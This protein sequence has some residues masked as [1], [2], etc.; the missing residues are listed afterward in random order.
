M[1][2]NPF[3]CDAN[4]LATL[5]NCNSDTGTPKSIRSDGDIVKSVTLAGAFVPA[6]WATGGKELTMDEVKGMYRT[7]D[8]KDMIDL[9]VNT[10]QIPVPCDTFYQNGEV[11]STV[12]KLLEK[13]TSVGL[14]AIIVLVKAHDEKDVEV[15]DEMIDRHV[16]AAAKYASTS[17]SVI[18]LQLPSPTPSLLGAIRAE[19]ETLSVLVPTNTGTMDSLSFPPDSNLFAAL[20]TAATTSVADVASSDSVGDRMKMFYREFVCFASLNYLVLSHIQIE[21]VSNCVIDTCFSLA[22]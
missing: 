2:G 6:L 11:A 10:I 21:C 12:S 7:K 3:A 15:T 17:S 4:G 16:S 22:R 13:A 19:A 1:D 14:S 18:A 9:G 5:G 8:F 20:D